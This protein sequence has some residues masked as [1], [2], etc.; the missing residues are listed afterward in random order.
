MGSGTIMANPFM[1]CASFHHSFIVWS[2]SNP[3]F[4]SMETAC[5]TVTAL[6]KVSRIK[7]DYLLQKQNPHKCNGFPSSK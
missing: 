4:Q 5:C 3:D 2:T 1:D 7:P 6:N